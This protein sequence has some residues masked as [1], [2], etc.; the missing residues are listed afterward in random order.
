MFK[1][2]SCDFC[3]GWTEDVWKNLKPITRPYAARNPL[4]HSKK[5]GK[6]SKLTL[7]SASV[8]SK[9]S[10]PNVIDVAQTVNV[11]D[12]DTYCEMVIVDDI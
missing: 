7:L 10:K 2:K 4:N 11:F 8:D 12:V 5:P 1:G 3:V 9:F 6:P